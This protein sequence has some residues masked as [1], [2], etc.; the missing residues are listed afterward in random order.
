MKKIVLTS[1]L[2]FCLAFAALAGG[3]LKTTD[4]K[5]QVT[6]QQGEPL[7]GV[8]VHLSSIDKDVYTDFDG[9][10]VVKDVPMTE[11]N[12]QLEYVSFNK[13]EVLVDAASLQSNLQLELKSR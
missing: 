5:G 4:L 13:Q 3:N 9:K 2:I 1:Q 6:D 11:Q 12:I 7:I 10:F 8:K